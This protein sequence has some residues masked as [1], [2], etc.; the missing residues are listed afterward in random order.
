M[1]KTS[2]NATAV[3]HW[4]LSDLLAHPEKDFTTLSQKLEKQVS[5]LERLRPRLKKAV[6]P[7]LF[8][9]AYRLKESI[10]DISVTLNA[11]AFLW[12]AENTQQ[13]A[14]RAFEAKVRERLTQFDNRILFLDLWWQGLSSKTTKPLLGQAGS[15]RYYLE[16]L[17]RLKPHT[18]S[19][20]QEQVISIKNSTG[21]NAIEMLYGV[22][23]TSFTFSLK[24]GKHTQQLT[25]EELMTHARHSS[26][27]RRKAAYQELFRVYSTHR[28]MIGEMYKTLVLD[29][30]NE[31]L[32][33]R[34]HRTP[35]A[36]RN[37]ANDI[38]DQAVTA[39]LNTCQKN[40]P[41]FSTLLSIEGPTAQAQNIFAL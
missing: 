26:A 35:I 14:P 24:V 38:P 25:R 7:K 13:Q 12:F 33:L 18:L 39:L 30:K 15:L 40:A 9:Q 16:S 23:T 11:F 5:Q 2:G 37:I 31:G 28:D 20:V 10:S 34:Q 1:P 17:T 21:R 32:T 36:V 41:L 19:E 27:S 29:W 22:L 4:N 6:S 3:P 8:Q